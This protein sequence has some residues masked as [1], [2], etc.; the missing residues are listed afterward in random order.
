[1]MKI[2]RPLL[3]FGESR[4]DCL[5]AAQMRLVQRLA[6]AC[7]AG[8]ALA[9]TLL[10]FYALPFK[11]EVVIRISLLLFAALPGIVLEYLLERNARAGLRCDPG[12]AT[13]TLYGTELLQLIFVLSLGVF[14]IE[15]IQVARTSN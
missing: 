10:W 8:I 4:P 9:I 7:F 12:Q 14:V 1:M 11:V 5:M 15:M 2:T 13:A 3:L 6:M